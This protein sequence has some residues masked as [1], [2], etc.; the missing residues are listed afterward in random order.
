MRRSGQRRNGIAG[1]SGAAQATQSGALEFSH[2]GIVRTAFVV[3]A[4]EVKGAVREQQ[5][6]FIGEVD[7]TL[8]GTSCGDGQSDDQRAQIDHAVGPAQT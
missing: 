1:G 8:S 3:E 2:L 5:R 4:E 7:A 6:D